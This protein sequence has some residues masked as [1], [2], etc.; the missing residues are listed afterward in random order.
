MTSA[1]TL[2]QIASITSTQ[3]FKNRV[4]NGNMSID[5]RFQGSLMT[6]TTGSSSFRGVDRFYAINFVG[7]GGQI[8]NTQQRVT[9]TDFTVPHNFALRMTVGNTSGRTVFDGR[10]Q[11]NIE[12]HMISDLQFGTSNADPMTASFWIRGNKSGR[13][14]FTMFN[15]GVGTQVQFLKNINIT[16]GWQ[17]VTISIPPCTISGAGIQRGTARAF[18]TGIYWATS[19]YN[20]NSALDGTWQTSWTGTSSIDD[21]TASG[22]WIEMTGYQIEKGSSAT[23]FDFRPFSV[24]LLLCQRYF[25][26]VRFG[27]HSTAIATSTSYS[28]DRPFPMTGCEFKAEK[29]VTPTITIFSGQTRTLNQV[30]GYSS[31]SERTVSSFSGVDTRRLCTFIQLASST[32]SFEQQGFFYNA[33]ADL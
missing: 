24:E 23:G 29:R 31:G 22:D 13:A 26:T 18:G 7:S 5:Q 4:I 27:T 10:F 32:N 12:G 30:S 2:A 19:G 20:T 28:N 21:F 8:S 6:Y 25:E 3:G 33:D 15:D 1:V 11:H 9:V 17:Y 16:T 14:H